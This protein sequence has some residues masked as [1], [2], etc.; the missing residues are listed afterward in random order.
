MSGIMEI[1]QAERPRLEQELNAAK[2]V[3]AAADCMYAALERIRLE[4]GRSMDR[5]KRAQADRVFRAAQEAV[6]CIQAVS[7]AEVKVLADTQAIKTNKDKLVAMLPAGAMVVGAVLTVWLVLEKIGPAAML[8]A[9]LTG[10]AWLETQVVYRRK[11]AVEAKPKLSVN[12]MLRRMDRLAEEI[13]ES[14]GGGE[15]EAPSSAPAAEDQPRV[16]SDMLEPVQ[17][18]L[19]AVETEDGDYALKAVPKLMAAL[20]Q[21]GIEAVPYSREKE[22]FFEMLPGTEEGLTIRPALFRDGKLIARGQATEKM[23]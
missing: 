19:E 11:M 6:K 21:Q 1:Y 8:A 17:M 13:A 22:E 16:N 15:T 18:L 9:I 5:Q 7:G 23:E 14:A 10:I 2:D 4:A 20:M 12:E 3:K